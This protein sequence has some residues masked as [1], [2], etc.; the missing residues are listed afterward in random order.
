MSVKVTAFQV[1]TTGF[2]R[3]TANPRQWH[4]LIGIDLDTAPGVYS[5]HVAAVSAQGP[6]ETDLPIRVLAKKFPTRRLSVDEAFVNPPESARARI[7]AESKETAAIFAAGAP[8]RLWS[9]FIRPVAQPAN[10][11]F[12][13]RS[14]FNGQP[15]NAHSGADFLSPA[16]TPVKT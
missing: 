3:D 4:A 11:A 9:A 15:R 12:G 6:L 14:V 5:A 8:T 13:M 1:E 7:D 10:S 16:G 2:Q